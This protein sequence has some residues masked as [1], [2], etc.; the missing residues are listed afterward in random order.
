MASV[1]YA[2]EAGL[3]KANPWDGA[4]SDGVLAAALRASTLQE[5]GGAPH[6]SCCPT[7]TLEFA[8]GSSEACRGAVEA[9]V[10]ALATAM[11]TRPPRFLVLYGSLRASSYSRLLAV[12]AARQLAKYG[13]AAKVFDPA[14]LPLFSQDAGGD[15]AK[16][17]EL[18]ALVRWCEGMVWCSPEVHGTFSA[19]FKNQVDWMP[20]SE[21]AVRPT[22]GK[23]L[24]VMQVEGGSQ[25]F[26]TV[27]ALRVLGRWMRCVVV[28]NQ[29]SIPRCHAEFA[30]GALKPGPA[31]DRVVDVVDELF[32]FTLL[33]RDQSPYLAARYSEVAA[34]VRRHLDDTAAPL[35][36]A[37]LG[38]LFAAG[39]EDAAR[40]VVVLDVRSEKERAEHVGGEPVDGSVHAPLNVDG[41]PQSAHET[42]ADEFRAKLEDAGV[43]L[44]DLDAATATFVAHCAHPGV[45]RGRG[46]RAAAILRAL[47]FPRAHNGGHA[48]NVRDGLAAAVSM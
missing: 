29:A 14:G 39:A 1:N 35:D 2:D 44:G 47:G 16:V 9:T 12:E 8:G 5:L 7:G 15:D 33:V 38:A 45:A 41:Q 23:T 20:L 40:G 43:R 6:V 10:A 42:L 36:P 24:A 11:S 21:G 19:V 28:P 3:T 25:S 32:K 4:D 26:N 48:D 13:A 34:A 46:A 37:A 17:L 27:C 30:G 31:R 22:Q 18:R